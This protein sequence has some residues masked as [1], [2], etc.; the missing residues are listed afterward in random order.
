MTNSPVPIAKL[1]TPSAHTAGQKWRSR[2]DASRKGAVEGRTDE[3]E[4]MGGGDGTESCIDCAAPQQ[5]ALAA[6]YSHRD[7]AFWFTHGAS[8]RGMPLAVSH[9]PPIRSF[10]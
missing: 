8:R 2:S 9:L 1:P 3:A 7:R 6:G 5:T 10:A 4:V